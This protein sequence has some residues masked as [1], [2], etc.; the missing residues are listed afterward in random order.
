MLNSL[1]M[2]RTKKDTAPIQPAEE[3]QEEASLNEDKNMRG[4]FS[5]FLL[6]Q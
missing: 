6:I 2:K 4:F 3:Q 5:F 1:E